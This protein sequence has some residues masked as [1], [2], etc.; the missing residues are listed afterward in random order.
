MN[1]NV[2]TE[3]A[4]RQRRN[5]RPRSVKLARSHG[6]GFFHLRRGDMLE[7]ERRLTFL[8]WNG[9][10][11]HVTNAQS[12]RPAADGA[13]EPEHRVDPKGRRARQGRARTD[14]GIRCG[15]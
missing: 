12:E 9:A 5:A 2:M 15:R 3:R 1:A 6:L 10:I 14:R 4:A 11:P 8:T 7:V 13:A